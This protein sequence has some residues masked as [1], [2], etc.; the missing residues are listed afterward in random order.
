MT[1][2]YQH[3][4]AHE[5][6][7]SQTGAP[8]ASD[9]EVIEALAHAETSPPLT[10]RDPAH[11]EGPGRG[12]P[13]RPSDLGLGMSSPASKTSPAH[14]LP[15][16]R[17]Q[18]TWGGW[19][20]AGVAATAGGASWS[21]VVGATPPITSVPGRA[22]ASM[23]RRR[24]FGQL[25]PRTQRLGW[26]PLMSSALI[27]MTVVLPVF[28]GPFNDNVGIFLAVIGVALAPSPYR[29][30]ARSSY[31]YA[32]GYTPVGIIALLAGSLTYI[33]ALDPLTFV[34]NTDFSIILA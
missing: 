9:D 29:Y 24:G 19:I 23:P 31:L 34:P 21:F 10:L 17:S 25:S 7:P 30:D 18:R 12:H 27:P 26:N 28:P 3:D 2:A 20:A 4:E 16:P 8:A 22:T 5:R 15:I 14:A 33:A 1:M 6:A 13:R 11:L 32:S